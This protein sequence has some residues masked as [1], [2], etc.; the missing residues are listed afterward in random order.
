M[1][2]KD[3]LKGGS[4]TRGPAK[5]GQWYKR[6]LKGTEVDSSTLFAFSFSSPFL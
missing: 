6:A 5:R 4:G 2:Q 3:R 1:V